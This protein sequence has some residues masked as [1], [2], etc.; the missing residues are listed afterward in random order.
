MFNGGR[1]LLRA[2]VYSIRHDNHVSRSAR[3]ERFLRARN[4][5]TK[6][7]NYVCGDKQSCQHPAKSRCTGSTPD[8][9]CFPHPARITKLPDATPLRFS[10]G[11]LRQARLPS[12]GRWA[13]DWTAC[14]ALHG[15]PF[16]FHAHPFNGAETE[17]TWPH[18]LARNGRFVEAFQS[19]LPCPV[20]FP[21]IF[22]FPLD[23][24]HFYIPRH[25]VPQRGVSRSS[26]TLGTG[27]GGRGSVGHAT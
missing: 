16:A 21:K 11:A 4:L 14:Q 6:S 5:T 1:R 9:G 3:Y 27:C 22:P 8:G 17:D 12:L 10:F 23:P 13:K 18:G 7:N 2:F 15:A 20:P 24:N 26:R 25:P 19:D